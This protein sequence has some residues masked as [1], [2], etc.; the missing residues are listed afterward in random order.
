MD[1]AFIRLCKNELGLDLVRSQA[2]F[3]SPFEQVYDDYV[4]GDKLSTHY[5]VLGYQIEINLALHNLPK[6]KR[7]DFKWFSK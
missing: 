2:T 5:V 1:E 6:E 7:V 3:L 4:F